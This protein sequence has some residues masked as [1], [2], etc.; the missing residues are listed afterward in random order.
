[1]IE[2]YVQIKWVH[3]AAIALS[4]VLF[5]ARGAY[6][7]AGARWPYAGVVRYLSYAIDS[8]LLTA[9]LMLATMLP[10]A[11]FANQWLT[12]KLLLVVFYIALGVFALRRGRPQKSRLIGFVF[13]LLT[14]ILIVGIAIAHHPLG[15]LRLIW[16]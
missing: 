1:V 4:G 10:S 9:A 5:T 13:A 15:W 3:I 6:A 11:L 14:Y 16:N 7:I 8:V 2:F 12:V